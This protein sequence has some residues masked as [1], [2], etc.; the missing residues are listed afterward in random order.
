MGFGFRSRGVGTNV[1][2]KDW[3]YL[4][5]KFRSGSFSI[6]C[7]DTAAIIPLFPSAQATANMFVL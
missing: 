6:T 2:E 1:L 5:P 7:S 4:R 3:W